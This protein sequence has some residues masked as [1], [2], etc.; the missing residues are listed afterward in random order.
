MDKGVT[1][2]EAVDQLLPRFPDYAE[3]ILAYKKRWHEM[4]RG[5]I[6][7]TVKILSELK[8][9]GYPIY[10]L[11]NWSS[12]TF[13]R[14]RERFSFLNYFDNILVSGTVGCMK[15]DPLI[16]KILF[17]NFNIVP[18]DAL[19]IDD[20]PANVEASKKAGMKAIRFTDPVSLRREMEEMG[21]FKG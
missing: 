17:R 12:E 10:A 21:V 6:S 9:D 2:Q 16:F 4:I 11:T 14:T 8:Q 18:E 1:F 19:F 20:S 13:S 15:P 5:E 7:S 3:Y